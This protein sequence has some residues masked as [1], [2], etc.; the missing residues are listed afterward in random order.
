VQ[1]A[2]AEVGSARANWH[3]QVVRACIEARCGIRLGRS[4]CTRS[5]HRR[6]F[7]YKRP[8]QRLRKADEARRAAFVAASV[9]LLAG[10]RARGAQICCADAA[11]CRAAADRHGTWARK[12]HPALVDPT[13]PRRGEQASDYSAVCLERGAVAHR[14]LTGN[15]ASATSVTFLRQWRANH[16]GPLVVIGDNGPAHG[17]DAVRAYLATPDPALRLVRLPAYRPDRNPDEAIWARAREEVTANTCRGTT[18]QVQERMQRCFGGLLARPAAVRSPC[19]RPWPRHRRLPLRRLSMEIPSA[20]RFSANLSVLSGQ[21]HAGPGSPL[22]PTP[23]CASPGRSSPIAACPGS[24][25]IRRAGSPRTASAARFRHCCWRSARPPA[26]HNPAAARPD[27][28][29]GA[30]PAP[31]RAIRPSRRPP[32]ATFGRGTP[33]PRWLSPSARLFS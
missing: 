3:W 23:S 2:P 15:S 32:D 24:V 30:A 9:A 22:P 13:C 4:A 1:A 17:G 28:R 27:G 5:R 31:R 14:A 33:P 18:A 11:H 26:R 29:K 21:P 19:P 10:T 8:Q 20:L 25:P 16:A 6:G 12:G 7:A